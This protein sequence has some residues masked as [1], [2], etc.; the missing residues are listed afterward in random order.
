MKNIKLILQYDGTNYHGFQIQ[1]DVVTVQS[2]LQDA[3]FE[4]TGVETKVNGCSRTDAG[5]HAINYC[6]GFVT[7]S[8]IP[9]ERFSLV[10]NNHLPDDIRVISSCEMQDDFHPRFSTV[11]KEYVYTIDTSGEVNV[12]SRNYSW[13]YKSDLD[14][15]LMNEAA[16][17]IVGEQD[18]CSFMTTGPVMETT[19]R[20]VMSLNISQKDSIVKIN[21]RADGF[22]YNMVRIITGTLVLV[23]EGKIEPV[24]V[25]EIISAKNRSLAGPTAPPQGLAL[26]RIYY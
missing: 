22:L 21:I 24:Y 19:V 11:S 20:N 8:P 16:S 26:Y 5:V 15:K 3:L 12:F 9:A 14:I 7:E 2:A 6:A 17:Y 23:G 10:L 25:K 18:F 4:I 13:Q 1:P